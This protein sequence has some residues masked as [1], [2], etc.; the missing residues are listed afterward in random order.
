MCTGVKTNV[1]TAIEIDGKDTGDAPML[2]PLVKTTAKSFE[3]YEVSADKGYSSRDVHDAIA[4]VGAIPFVAFKAGATGGVGG[5]FGKMFHFFQYNREEFLAHYHRR[6][7][8]ESTVMMIKAKFGD[9]V[10][11]KTDIAAKNEVL[12]KVLCHNICCLISAI[13]EL[14]QFSLGS[15]ALAS[16]LLASAAD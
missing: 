3:M 4:S 11:S 10:R 13:Y 9:A 5:L 16:R 1:V 6:S 12:C 7:N 8:V 15:S 14:E 2:P